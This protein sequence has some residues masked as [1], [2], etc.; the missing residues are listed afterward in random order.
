VEQVQ[1]LRR[2]LLRLAKLPDPV[3]L[4]Q[5]EKPWRDR[6]RWGF[7]FIAHAEGTGHLTAEN[8]TLPLGTPSHLASQSAT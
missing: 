6:I 2:L 1:R 4:G 5:Q 7:F 8:A 3:G